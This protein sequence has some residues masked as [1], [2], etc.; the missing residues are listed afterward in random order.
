MP[1]RPYLYTVPLSVGTAVVCEHCQTTIAITFTP[2]D[3][4][5]IIHA[6]TCTTRPEQVTVR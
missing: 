4:A 1:N 5:A 3:A 2:A 6:H